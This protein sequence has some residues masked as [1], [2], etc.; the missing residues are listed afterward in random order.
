MTDSQLTALKQLASL[1]GWSPTSIE[2][3]AATRYYIPETNKP[4]QLLPHQIAILN[5]AFDHDYQTIVYS[6]VKKSGK[7]AIAA[8]VARWIAETCGN[9]TEVYLIAND[10]E[11]ARGRVYQKALESIELTPGYNITQRVLPGRWRIVERQATF[12][13]TRSIMRAVSGDY[14]GEAGS[15][16]TATF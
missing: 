14:K 4:I 12:L 6:T 10:Y 15:N 3:F 7:T 9:N 1:F 11:Q 5:Y 13:P 2:D 16:P 8:L